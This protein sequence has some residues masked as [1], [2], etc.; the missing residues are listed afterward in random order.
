MGYRKDKTPGSKPLSPGEKML[1]ALS[2]CSLDY[3]HD[4]ENHSLDNR[5]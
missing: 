5:G 2:L 1:R 3:S 4:H